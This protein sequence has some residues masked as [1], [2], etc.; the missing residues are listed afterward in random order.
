MIGHLHK[1][2]KSRQTPETKQIK[3]AVRA[4]RFALQRVFGHGSFQSPVFKYLLPFEL[5]ILAGDVKTNKRATMGAFLLVSLGLLQT[6]DQRDVL[7][8][9]KCANK[10]GDHHHTINIQADQ[11]SQTF[12]S[13]V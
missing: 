11:K 5:P 6:S 8:D 7:S 4:L 9:I 10:C 13:T 2:Q 3:G 12:I 1:W